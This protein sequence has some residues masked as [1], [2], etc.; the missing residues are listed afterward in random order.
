MPPSIRLLSCF[1]ILTF[2]ALP[3]A[4][5]QLAFP[6]AEGFGRFAS[7]G[8]GGRVIEVIN[9][10][11]SGP[12]SLRAAI[13]ASGPRTVVF[14]VSGTIYLENTLTIRNGNLT[15]AGQ[16]APGDGITI[17][18]RGL[19]VSGAN[20]VIIRFIRV[21]L[22]DLYPREKG[23]QY[24][25]SDAFECRNSINVII[26]HCSFSWSTDEVATA[27]NNRDFTMQWCI[28]SE[29]LHNSFHSKGNHGYG[30]I[31]GGRNATFHHNLIA[32]CRSRTPR[33]QGARDSSYTQWGDDQVDHRHNVIYNWSDNSAYGAEPNNDG[34]RPRYNIV[35]NA[36]RP[37]PA[38]QS[39]KRDRILAA[40]INSS[41]QYSQ[42]HVEGNYVFDALETS[43]DN[44]LGVDNVSLAD[45]ETVLS[46]DPFV[47]PEVEYYPALE[48]YRQVLAHAGASFP[49]RDSV[50][51]R[52]LAE[53]AAG[54]APHGNNGLIDSQDEVGGYPELNTTTPPVDLD[55]DGMPDDW[56]LA[57]GLSPEDP[58]DRNLD[59]DG[60][61]YT[62]LEE[63]L[64][65]L[66]SGI[67]LGEP[68]LDFD[69][70]APLGIW[71]PLRPAAR[72]DDADG[73]GWT[74]AYEFAF[75]GDP[76]L[77]SYI[78]PF[79]TVRAGETLTFRH[80]RGTR[81]QYEIQSTTD[82]S[83]W[84]REW[85]IEDGLDVPQ[86]TVLSENYHAYAL[87]YATPA[88]VGGEGRFWRIRVSE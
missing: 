67:A 77:G 85:A 59:A 49:L 16:T 57:R 62:N 74:N 81:L 60:N 30:G 2:M 76:L 86:L 18:R 50:D 37:G 46:E 47:M 55:Q 13:D 23:L 58:E 43:R 84:T 3:G 68:L 17:A 20:N 8:R 27:Y 25:E 48:A 80:R 21:R 40:D 66:V 63:Y 79:V 71:D 36:Y 45:K 87:L 82:L 34:F 4:A 14:R 64:N 31:W 51:V 22:G 11:D 28:V 29:A 72:T 7:G 52:V 19:Q 75:A 15:I 10:N 69:G 9:L 70:W 42:F 41:F 33:F 73:D 5:Q 39:S 44:D 1:F 54:S 56:E 88:D 83:N 53:V 12:G 26:D 61:G 6:G 38:T 35:G 24:F 32:H 78:E 65:S